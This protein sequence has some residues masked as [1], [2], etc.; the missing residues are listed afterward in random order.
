MIS[1]KQEVVEKVL[2]KILPIGR[3]R[4]V[5]QVEGIKR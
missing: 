4:D 2:Y 1:L 3:Y 5:S